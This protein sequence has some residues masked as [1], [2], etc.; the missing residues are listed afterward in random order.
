MNVSYLLS[1]M[2]DRENESNLCGLK[3]GR[4]ADMEF[5]IF[6]SISYM[7]VSSNNW[8]IYAGRGQ[9]IGL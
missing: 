4:V 6:V 8:E 7:V 1:Q 9:S 2:G 5:K 3:P